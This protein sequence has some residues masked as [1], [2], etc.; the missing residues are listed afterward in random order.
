MS[1]KVGI[2]LALGT[3]LW[4]PAFSLPARDDSAVDLRVD[5]QRYLPQRLRA[6]QDP[7]LALAVAISGGGHRAGNF[8][9]GVLMGLEAIA[10]PHGNLLREVDYFSTV[11]G[12]GFAVGVYLAGL[13]DQRRAAASDRSGPYAFQGLLKNDEHARRALERGYTRFAAAYCENAN[14]EI[15]RG[16]LLEQRFDD[17][18]LGREKRSRHVGNADSLRLGDL[19]KPAGSGAAARDLAPYWVA[20]ATVMEH[21]GQ[22][23]FA[24]DVLADM[25]ITAY[26]HRCTEHALR[27]PY[28]LPLSV[29]MKASASFPVG[30]P[31]T[32]M[33]SARDPD[34]PY[35]RLVDGGVSDNLGVVTAVDLLL[36]DRRLN[37]QTIRR[38]VLI[39]I[40]AYREEDILLSSRNPLLGPLAQ[41]YKTMKL[42]MTAQHRSLLRWLA[43]VGKQEGIQVIVLDMDDIR[44]PELRESTKGILAQLHLR[45]EEQEML[46]EAG[47]DVV[48]GGLASL[49]S[50]APEKLE[51]QAP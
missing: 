45:K 28:D 32:V 4:L 49:R 14:Y 8:A 31:Q 18:L 9:T 48:K 20:N 10:T 43:S 7:Q 1:S 19:F 44:D 41:A 3:L 24:P 29:G 13:L 25:K 17:W 47:R 37:R 26:S 2:L 40:D 11:S 21:G 5:L 33:A 16:T 30:M 35:L 34:N 12:G 15:L 38:E 39:V 36:Q 22:F 46:F 23:P 27:D 42:L 6:G 51:T 50:I